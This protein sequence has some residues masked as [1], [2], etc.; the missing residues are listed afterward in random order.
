[1]VCAIAVLTEK[2]EQLATLTKANLLFV[3]FPAWWLPVS[4]LG[5]DSG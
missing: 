3:R 2:H 4:A 1:M 5:V